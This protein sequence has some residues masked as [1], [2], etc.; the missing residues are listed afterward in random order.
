MFAYP[1]A[2]SNVAQRVRRATTS[3]ADM[4]A[5]CRARRLDKAGLSR[6]GVRGDGTTTKCSAARCPRLMGRSA[7]Y[8]WPCRGVMDAHIENRVRENV[9]CPPYVDRRLSRLMN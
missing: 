8:R 7:L 3:G 1:L 4:S 6:H 2:K 9:G 5:Q